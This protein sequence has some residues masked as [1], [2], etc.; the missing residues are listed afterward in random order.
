MLLC[1][2]ERSCD[3]PII[4]ALFY[5]WMISIEHYSLRRTCNL[6]YWCRAGSS[7]DRLARD[8]WRQRRGKKRSGLTSA[9]AGSSSFVQT[10]T[11]TLDT[12]HS[13]IGDVLLFEDIS[14]SS[15]GNSQSRENI[16]AFD[17]RLKRDD[18]HIERQAQS[19]RSVTE[20]QTDFMAWQQKWHSRE[21]DITQQILCKKC[22]MSSFMTF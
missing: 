7:F 18:S 20:G 8:W 12:H 11:H 10:P 6:T 5:W 4:L 21:V 17:V 1:M 14:E 13:S 9:R 3:F 16:K 22:Q 15:I 2:V 19:K